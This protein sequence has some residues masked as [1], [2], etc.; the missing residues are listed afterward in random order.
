MWGW[1]KSTAGAVWDFVKG[2]GSS[3][4][5]S[6]KWLLNFVF[7]LPDFILTLLGIMPW[8]K[9][10]VQGMI[11]LDEKRQPVATR[12][13]VE[14]VIDLAEE[15]FADQMHV[16]LVRPFE[17]VGVV[18]EAAPSYALEVGCDADIWG[19]QFTNVGAWFRHRQVVGPGTIF[20]YG[21]PITLFVVRNVIDKRGCAPPAFLADYAVIDP[22]ALSGDEGSLLT[23]AHEVGHACNL[24][25]WS[26]TLMQKGHTG[27]PR[28]LKRLQKAIFRASGHVTYL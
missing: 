18:P 10:R 3:I 1:I 11:L 9:V 26:S 19:A 20:G 4:W 2:V 22:D 8:K 16:R 14:A 13:A 5:Q 28:K 6:I 12:E 15:V 27:R 17:R 25:H 7:G 21:S 23:A 24:L